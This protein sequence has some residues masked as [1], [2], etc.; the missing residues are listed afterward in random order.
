M[1]NSWLTM[2]RS[3]QCHQRDG[4]DRYS[5]TWTAETIGNKLTFILVG[6]DSDARERMHKTNSYPII[7]FKRNKHVDFQPLL[8]HSHYKH[9]LHL[10]SNKK[11]VTSF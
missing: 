10:L 6:S 7:S 11:T 8:C 4:Q 3:N 1:S 2:T 5:L 9:M